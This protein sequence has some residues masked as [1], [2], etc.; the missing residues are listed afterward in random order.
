MKI[1]K[2]DLPIENEEDAR[3]YSDAALN[4]AFVE[5]L[6]PLCRMFEFAEDLDHVVEMCDRHS[7]QDYLYD[8]TLSID[9]ARTR[10][11]YIFGGYRTEDSTE[12]DEEQSVEYID[13][14]DMEPCCIETPYITV[15][16]ADLGREF[17]ERIYP[18]IPTN[19]PDKYMINPVILDDIMTAADLRKFFSDIVFGYQLEEEYW[20]NPGCQEVS[21]EELLS[22]NPEDD[23]WESM[24][25]Q[26]IDDDYEM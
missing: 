14:S 8:M 3:L 21:L 13:Y 25:G 18:F 26:D 17:T 7:L 19:D 15:T 20:D 6:A 10:A 5:Q 11:E 9:E 12:Y 24:K 1:F 22:P 23:A 2:L 4:Y 16:Q